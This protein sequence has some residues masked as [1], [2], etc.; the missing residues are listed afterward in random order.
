MYNHAN[1]KH[2][3]I[4]YYPVS[5]LVTLFANI[6]QNP[7]DARARGDLR[8]MSSVCSFLTMLERDA[9]EPSGNVRRMLSVCSEFERIAKVVLDKAERE[10]RGRGK[11]KAAE[12]ER[13]REKRDS[14]SITQGLD[15]GKTL[16]QIQV[17]T[18][19]AYRRPVQTPSLRQSLEGSVGNSPA[20]WGSTPGG[21]GPEYRSPNNGATN[22]GY[23][24]QQQR[25]QHQ[26]HSHTNS[27]QWTQPGFSIP[28]D[29][30]AAFQQQEFSTTSQP[31]QPSFSIPNDGFD[32][33][34]TGFTSD[35]LT[36]FDMSGSGAFNPSQ[37]M[38]GNG[39]SSFQQPFVPQDLWQM[40]MTLEWDWAEG[41]GLGSFTPG[42]YMDGLYG[43]SGLEGTGVQPDLGDGQ[44]QGQQ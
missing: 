31:S 29:A 30:P 1:L 10:L 22:G 23:Q 14:N 34:S 28:N 26:S 2:R 6:L 21:S 19:A 38:S 9:T 27:G 5:A 13:E 42:P 33:A 43:L 32:P 4:L 8:L 12:K 41:L 36:S 18:Q 15:D 24:Q 7:Q 25:N 3:L 20:S 35:P 44:G 37:T 17:E 11:R 16:E 40:P 39:A